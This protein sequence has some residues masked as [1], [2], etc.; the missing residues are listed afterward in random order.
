MALSSSQQLQAHLTASGEPSLQ[1]FHICVFIIYL[2][3]HDHPILLP[4]RPQPQLA[5]TQRSGHGSSPFSLPDPTTNWV[6]SP[7]Q[8]PLT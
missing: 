7:L 2:T 1:I 3:A 6:E 5:A 8:R 4:K